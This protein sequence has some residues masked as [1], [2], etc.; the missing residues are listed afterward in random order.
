MGLMDHWGIWLTSPSLAS[1]GALFKLLF[2]RWGLLPSHVFNI[3]WLYILVPFE[4]ITL[5]GETCSCA[6]GCGCEPRCGSACLSLPSRLCWQSWVRWLSLLA[7]GELLPCPSWHFA[8]HQGLIGW[9][10]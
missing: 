4:K 5:R 10:F 3:L 2:S 1:G 8:S 9:L 6:A 7:P